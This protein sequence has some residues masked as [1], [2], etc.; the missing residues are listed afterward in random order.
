VAAEATGMR[1]ELAKA[2][3]VNAAR[4]VVSMMSPADRWSIKGRS[5]WE[6]PRADRSVYVVGRG[7]PSVTRC[8]AGVLRGGRY[9]G[10]VDD[11]CHGRTTERIVPRTDAELARSR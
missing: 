2:S 4:I 6:L 8:S 3:V 9:N 10:S 11:G 5:R 1:T 7:P